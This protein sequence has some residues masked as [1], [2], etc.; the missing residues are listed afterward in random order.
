[1]AE[2]LTEPAQRLTLDKKP[3]GSM[4]D[5]YIRCYLDDP[6]A[7]K[8]AAYCCAGGE[9]RHQNNMAQRAFDLHKRLSG[10]IEKQLAQ[11]IASGGA[12]GVVG[13]RDKQW[14]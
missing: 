12:Q 10:D 9:G 8:A 14:Q 3:P 5:E 4:D 11:R 13:G 7:G 2:K 1:M 6:G